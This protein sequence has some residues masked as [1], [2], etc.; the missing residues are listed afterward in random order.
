MK[1]IYY[2]YIFILLL[3]LSTIFIYFPSSFA[4]N[5]NRSDNVLIEA[6]KTSGAKIVESNVNVYSSNQNMFLGEDELTDIVKSLA[7]RMG[8]G[9]GES[10]KKEHYCKDY[11]QITLIGDNDMGQKIVIIGY[12]M[13]FE[14]LED[15]A[16][17]METDIVLDISSNGNY[18]DIGKIERKAKGAVNRFIKGSRVTSCIIGAFEDEIPKG[19][20]VE[21]INSIM[22]KID[23]QEVE[24]AVYDGMISISGYTPKISDH[25][26][27]GEN[28][29]N[30]NI[31]MRYNSYEGKTYI[32]IG[33]P[34][35]SLEY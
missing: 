16:E 12:S 5:Y 9:F 24:K 6:F 4:F 18:E 13:D 8:I 25:L 3:L 28:K 20:M 27:I 34:V 23:A 2:L 15:E 21:I 32:W 33:S 1:K 31:A 10:E 22:E 29:V 30:I 26:K 14:G 35:I 19:K 17:G 11:N 7:V